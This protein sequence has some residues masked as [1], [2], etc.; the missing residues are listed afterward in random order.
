MYKMKHFL[1]IRTILKYPDTLFKYKEAGHR[2]SLKTANSQKS[3]P[4]NVNDSMHS[5]LMW[6]FSQ[7]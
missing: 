1:D 6:G 5:Y 2:I 4:T 7:S 3:A